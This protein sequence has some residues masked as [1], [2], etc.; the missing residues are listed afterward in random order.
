[1]RVKFSLV[2]GVLSTIQHLV[3]EE[4]KILTG[5]GGVVNN[6]TLGNRGG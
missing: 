5:S 1:M 3:T 2:V 6:T 4:G